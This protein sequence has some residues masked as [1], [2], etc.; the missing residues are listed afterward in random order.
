MEMI[1]GASAVGTIILGILTWSL[2][3]NVKAMDT[4]IAEAKKSAADANAKA[5]ELE[6]HE[7]VHAMKDEFA[8]KFEEI[9]KALAAIG[10][11]VAVLKDRDQ[12]A[13]VDDRAQPR[14]R[15][16]RRN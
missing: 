12:N 6:K 15:R 13:R 5:V 11:D 4:Q 10:S 9:S 14:P 3:R 1:A 7:F 8:G 16:R 2:Q